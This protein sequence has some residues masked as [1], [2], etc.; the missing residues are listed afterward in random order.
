MN[1]LSALTKL[2]NAGTPMQRWAFG[3]PRK[4]SLSAWLALTL[5]GIKP[6]P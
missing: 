4:L 3:Q 1:K 5:Y 6:R 2:N